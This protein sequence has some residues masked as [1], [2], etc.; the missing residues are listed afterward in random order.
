MPWGKSEKVRKSFQGFG[1]TEGNFQM[2]IAPLIFV[3]ERKFKNW[4][5]GK[6]LEK[7][8]V[9]SGII[10]GAYLFHN[11]ACAGR[12]RLM[13]ALNIVKVMCLL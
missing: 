6:F 11:G 8:L 1:E 3:V 13:K 4:L 9:F 10:T 7:T 12:R 2:I 5:V